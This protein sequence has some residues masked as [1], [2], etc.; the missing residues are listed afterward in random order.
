MA[1]IEISKIQVRR[2][3]ENQTGIPPLDGGEF[4]WAADTESLY[5]GLRRE[6]GGARDANIRILT[7]NDLRNFFSVSAVASTT[8]PYTYRSDTNPPIT[9]FYTTGTATAIVRNV[10]DRLDDFVSIKNFLLYDDYDS[11]ATTEIIQLAVNRLFLTD[12]NSIYATNTGTT[13]AAKVLYFPTGQY[14]INSTIFLPANVTLVG[15][16]IDKTVFTRVTTGT[17][18]SGCIFQTIDKINNPEMDDASDLVFDHFD[19]TST[20]VFTEPASNITIEGMT[21]KYD[22]VLPVT[23]T[24]GIISLDCADHALIRNVKFQGT[25]FLTSTNVNY[26]GLNIRGYS[27]VTS[28]HITIDQCE[29]VN[30]YAGIKSNYDVNHI[31]ISNSYFTELERGVNFNDPIDPLAVLGPRNVL[32]ENN[33]FYKINQQAIYAGT[34]TSSTFFTSNIVSRNNYFDNVGNLVPGVGETYGTATSII[35]F[36]SAGNASIDDNFARQEYQNLYGGSLWYNDIIE[37]KAVLDSNIVKNA[38][39]ASGSE[40]VLMRLPINNQVNILDLKYY[41]TAGNTVDRTGVVTYMIT[42]TSTPNDPNVQINDTYNYNTNDGAIYWSA[43][44][45][46]EYSMIEV[47]VHNPTLGGSGLTVNVSYQSHLVL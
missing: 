33:K 19:T 45:Y 5:I 14:N 38:T 29:M 39:V 27:A 23:G 24:N 20:I 41:M 42:P 13:P 43:T 21:L 17:S 40:T 6:D 31:K 35:T 34:A 32:I 18:N 26:V 28:H 46:P 37:G 9:A 12:E 22:S 2:G 47:R 16:G 7:E 8:E 36:L 1:V 25:M 3:Q 30:L 44:V 4:A 15:E 10:S 11:T